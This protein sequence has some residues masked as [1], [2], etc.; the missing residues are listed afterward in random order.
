V[1]P[2]TGEFLALQYWKTLFWALPRGQWLDTAITTVML[3]F[4]KYLNVCHEKHKHVT[5]CLEHNSACADTL[6]V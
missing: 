1:E 5:V 2:R 4:Q 6:D 3:L